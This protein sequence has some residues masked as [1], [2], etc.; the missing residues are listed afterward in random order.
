MNDLV[1]SLFHMLKDEM[2]DDKIVIYKIPCQGCFLFLSQAQP[3]TAAVAII[4]RGQ[5]N[6]ITII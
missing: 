3:N 4:Q 6:D 2:K 5:L 1:L